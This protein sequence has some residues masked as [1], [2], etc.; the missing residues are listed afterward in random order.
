MSVVLVT[1]RRFGEVASVRLSRW[2][3]TQKLKGF[4]YV[5]F[6]LGESA[7][8]AV[9][10]GDVQVMDDCVAGVIPCRAVG[11]SYGL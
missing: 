10:A 8:A 4:G 5:Q 1:C 6:K 3:H 2:G 7:E 11:G 9:T